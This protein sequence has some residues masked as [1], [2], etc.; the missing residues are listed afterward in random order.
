MAAAAVAG[1]LQDLP[2][3][4]LRE[5]LDADTP[6]LEPLAKRS[7]SAS[8]ATLQHDLGDSIRYSSQYQVYLVGRIHK[9]GTQDTSFGKNTWPEHIAPLF[10][11]SMAVDTEPLSSMHKPSYHLSFCNVQSGIRL[12][13]GQDAFHLRL[14]PRPLSDPV[15]GYMHSAGIL[16]T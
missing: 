13:W 12:A 8:E 7:R 1:A 9:L 11:K 4:S 6:E 2:A 5:A 16:Y 15:S 3:G 14:S 10:V